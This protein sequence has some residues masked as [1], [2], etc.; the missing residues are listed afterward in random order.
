MDKR[1][2]MTAEMVETDME[3]YE[4]DEPAWQEELSFIRQRGELAAGDVGQRWTRGE[5]YCR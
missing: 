5:L 2:P 1:L 4:G 3:A